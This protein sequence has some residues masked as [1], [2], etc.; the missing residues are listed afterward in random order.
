MINNGI[1]NPRLQKTMVN[2]W[3]LVVWYPTF[4][5]RFKS[6]NG[7]IHLLPKIQVLEWLNSSISLHKPP[8]A[9][10]SLYC[11]EIHSPTYGVICRTF[12]TNHCLSSPLIIL[13]GKTKSKAVSVHGYI[14]RSRLP[15]T[16]LRIATE[17]I[18]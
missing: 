4:R 11:V 1:R 2:S 13:T 9:A 7:G 14:M 17:I 3:S 8:P 6:S 15:F 16:Y 10:L 12:Q 5:L 18:K